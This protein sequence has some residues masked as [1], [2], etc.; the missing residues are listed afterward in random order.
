M[1][2]I[3]TNGLS[4]LEPSDINFYGFHGPRNNTAI[5][6]SIVEYN[7]NYAYRLENFKANTIKKYDKSVAKLSEHGHSKIEGF[8][9][10]SQKKSLLNIRDQI[11]DLVDRNENLKMRTD[12]MAFINQPLVNLSGLNDI[13]FDDRLI[14]I[15]TKYF[16]CMPGFGSIA[17][18]KSFVGP[19]P[20]DSNQRFHRDYNSL[21]KMMKFAIYLNDVDEDGGPFTYVE[22]SNKKLFNDW[23]KFHY[24]NDEDIESVYGS[25]SI[26]YLP[27][28]FGDLLMANTKGFHKGQKPVARERIAM[29]F[30][31][32]I[33]PEMEGYDKVPKEKRFQ[34][35]EDYYKSMPDWKKPATD[36]LLKV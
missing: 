33:H 18:R 12:S 16:G 2:D 1:I 10:E 11:N 30:T 19:T 5:I 34:I 15:A 29:H 3:K 20:P 4:W 17:V 24:M 6:N 9:N 26:K 21:V 25:D 35:S 28:N 7:K 23:W 32:L 27:A 22:G 31:Y 14:K 13:V 8:F 36:F